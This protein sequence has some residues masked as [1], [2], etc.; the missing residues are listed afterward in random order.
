ME[1][2]ACVVEH[3]LRHFMNVY[4]PLVN[5]ALMLYSGTLEKHVCPLADLLTF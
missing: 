3:K 2:F 5:S 4:V 1:T